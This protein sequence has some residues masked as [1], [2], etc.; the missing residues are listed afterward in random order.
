M[1]TAPPP[2]LSNPR[3][4]RVRSVRAL[5]RR[6]MRERTGLFVAEGPQSVREAV[7]ARPDAVRELYLTADAATRHADIVA[8]A[9]SGRVA[10][11]TCTEDVLAAMADT[12]APQ[13]VLAV[14]RLPGGDPSARLDA[15]LATRPQL[16]VVLTHVRDPG[17][18]GTV[19][20]GADA[21]G[22]DGVL[23]SAG[24]V[25]VWSPKVVRSTAGSLFHVPVIA[26]IAA[27]Q[28]LARLRDD[29]IPLLAADGQGDVTL[30][31]LDAGLLALP[32]AWVFGNEAWGLPVTL[33]DRCDLVVRVPIRG[34]A[35]SLNLAMAATVCLYAS[36]THTGATRQAMADDAAGRLSAP[37]HGQPG[38]SRR[39][40][41]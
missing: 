11:Y 40:A 35:E 36:I 3:A 20:R 29:G 18:L 7:L 32:H 8:A 37:D 14:C 17:N 1:P 39:S 22:A 27:E 9:E 25:D 31:E 21:V 13:G 5:S 30:P 4:E 12:A 16:L 33:R 2:P 15:L 19:V 23:V 28:L 24:S 10:T 41:G 38:P 6:S 34:R 26:G